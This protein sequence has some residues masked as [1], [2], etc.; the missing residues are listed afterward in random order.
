MGK[1]KQGE[2]YLHPGRAVA[3]GT[4]SHWPPHLS[5]AGP[6]LSRSSPVHAIGL[7]V[8]VLIYFT[9]LTWGRKGTKIE[10][11][12]VWP[13]TSPDRETERWIMGLHVTY[14]KLRLGERK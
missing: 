4:G 10:R 11:S 12:D 1:R 14:V 2:P 9:L 7:I 3:G 13:F 5:L 8:E 6:S